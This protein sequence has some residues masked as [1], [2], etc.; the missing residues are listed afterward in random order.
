MTGTKRAGASAGEMGVAGELLLAG[1]G[2]A[3]DEDSALCA[4]QRSRPG[5]RWSA[6]PDPWA[7]EAWGRGFAAGWWRGRAQ[8]S[9]VD[10]VLR[11]ISIGD[12]WASARVQHYDGPNVGALAVT[13]LK[14][15][16][17]S[18]SFSL[19]GHCVKRGRLRNLCMARYGQGCRG[20]RAGCSMRVRLRGGSGPG[21][22]ARGTR[23]W[24]RA[25]LL[26]RKWRSR[27]S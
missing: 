16:F 24:S 23:R 21:D 26:E 9:V 7:N 11:R 10:F 19:S 3:A 12:W 18:I 22:R 27:F 14:V 8:G 15:A 13:R 25:T 2:F 6:P 1:A 5:G 4:P 17:G 20:C